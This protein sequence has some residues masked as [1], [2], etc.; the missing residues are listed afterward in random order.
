[1]VGDPTAS[2]A[3]AT[4]IEPTVDL[5]K[6]LGTFDVQDMAHRGSELVGSNRL[7]IGGLFLTAA[8][9]WRGSGAFWRFWNEEEARFI[10]ELGAVLFW[11]AVVFGFQWWASEVMYVVTH[12]V[13][14]PPDA[15]TLSD[16]YYGRMQKLQEY[17]DAHSHLTTS[18]LGT[19]S[20]EY[21]GM[22]ILRVA[23]A[24]AFL[25]IQVTAYM[26]NIGQVFGLSMLLIFG[27][28]I[29][30]LA[31]LGGF[32]S[33]FAIAWLMLFIEVCMWSPM[34]RIVML[35]FQQYARETPTETYSLMVEIIVCVVLFYFMR[36]VPRFAAALVHGGGAGWMA[37]QGGPMVAMATG[38]G[39]RAAGTSAMDNSKA[40]SKKGWHLGAR[41]G[42]WAVGKVAGAAGLQRN[43]EAANV[44]DIAAKYEREGRI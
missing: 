43:N 17:K 12:L 7:L 6:V 42:G 39:A 23:T 41:A 15:G 26:L 30:C 9:L 37:P 20:P 19:L 34:L 11:A 28:L 22:C 13:G 33:T 44:E 25:A 3:A 32:F 18:S 40:L 31:A 29:F 36:D 1:M 24:F 4:R 14:K 38:A 8:I 2:G 10:P 16:L 21:W 5:A 35:F 27:Q